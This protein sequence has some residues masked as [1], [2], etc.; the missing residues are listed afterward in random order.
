MKILVICQHYYPEPFRIPDIC[1]ELVRRGHEVTVVTGIPNYPEGVIYEG[2][3]HKHNHKEKYHGVDIN[4]CLTIPRKTG[5]IY[6]FLNYYSFAFSSSKFVSTLPDDFDIVFV[7]QLSPV[8]MAKAGLAYAKKHKKPILLYCL[9]LWPESLVAGGVNRKSPLYKYFSRVSKRIY[10]S[11]DK[12][13]VTSKMFADYMTTHF[14]I[15]K[16]KI[17]H[18]PQYAE[19]LFDSVVSNK[20]SDESEYNFLFAGN[21]GAI[22]SI[23]TIIEA[24]ALLKNSEHNIKFHIVGSGSD[25]DNLKALANS[26]GL[27]NV[28]FYGRKPL[29]EMPHYYAFADAMLIT[30]KNDP[31]INLT[32]PGKLQ[33]YM[34][35]GKPVIG[36]IDGETRK[37]I[38][39]AQ[40]GFCGDAESAK[41]LADNI[42]RF[43]LSDN[44]A[45]MGKNSRDYYEKF[46]TEDRFIES[47]I[48]ELE[49]VRRQKNENTGV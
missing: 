15:E 30:L 35:A 33:S 25:L 27:S 13:L 23:D 22:Q 29:E 39:E 28:I 2:Y 19:N 18:L 4:R 17:S 49:A 14:K 44:K 1:E 38:D 26:K 48:G 24:A 43:I 42:I 9:D 45:Q 41:Q 32:L 40:C 11:V 46:F 6:R 36:A 8:I 10:S 47:L 37:V 31:I 16:E 5:A 12:I 7:N 3:E 21:L 20:K 34:A